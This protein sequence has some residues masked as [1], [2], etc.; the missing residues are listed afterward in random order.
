MK[1]MLAGVREPAGASVEVARSCQPPQEL[2]DQSAATLPIRAHGVAILVVPLRPSRRKV[3][4]L[5]AALAQVPR[6]GDELYAR[7]HGVLPQNVEEGAQAVDFMQLA[8]Q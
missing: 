8:R 5:I 2:A 7:E 1:L 3:A 6:L 4:D